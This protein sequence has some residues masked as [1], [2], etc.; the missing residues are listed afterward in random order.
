[1]V[2]KITVIVPIYNVEEYLNRCLDSIINQTYSNLEIILINDGSTDNSYSI[3]KSY[4]E[5]DSR[6]ILL[7]Q[8]NQGQAKARNEGLRICTGDYLL[9]V[10]SDDWIESKCVQIC[11]E[12]V[13][14]TKSELIIFDI[15]LI[16]QKEIIYEEFDLSIFN[17]HSGPCN[18]FYSIDL[19]KDKKFPEQFWYE[20]LGVI[21]IIVG[22][23]EKKVKI[24]EA[25]YNYDFTRQESQSHQIN[26]KKNSDIIQMLE[27]V[28]KELSK[29]E[30]LLELEY[31]FI[32]HLILGLILRKASFIKNNKDRKYLIENALNYLEQ[33]FP[34]WPEN[35]YYVTNKSVLSQVEKTLILL[36]KKGQY[37]T[38]AFSWRFFISVNKI[39]HLT[40][41][42]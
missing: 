8:T 12:T 9:F 10:D 11:V 31:L 30:Y 24:N 38:A 5:L 7:N 29:D 23:C 18:K 37:S 40:L 2:P 27:L 4:E 13:L 16:K 25:L 20:D 14:R 15:R 22:K 42:S 35:K 26:I 1:M 39:R 34:N 3:A 6:I 32:K 28:Y 41:K 21:P 19:W 36:Y 17:S 33:K